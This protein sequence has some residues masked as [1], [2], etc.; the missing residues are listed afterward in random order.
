MRCDQVAIYH[1]IYLHNL[2]V[3]SCPCRYC[4]MSHE[5]PQ[6]IFFPIDPWLL[7]HLIS[8]NCVWFIEFWNLS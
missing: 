2:T 5:E 8:Y 3:I 7:Y 4:R 1:I 6:V